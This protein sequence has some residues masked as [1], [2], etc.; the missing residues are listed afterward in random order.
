[1]TTLVRKRSILA[2]VETA[3]G[4][5]AAPTLADAVTLTEFSPTPLEATVVER[6]LLRPFVGAASELIAQRTTILNPTCEL[7]G[8][9]IDS[10]ITGGKAPLRPQFHALLRACGM[11]ETAI[12]KD[13]TAAASNGSDRVG[14]RY[15]T[16]DPTNAASVTVISQVDGIQ[17][18]I[19]GC[20][21]TFVI[22][23]ENGGIP[24]IAFTMTGRYRRPLKTALPTTGAR[25]TDVPP[26][27]VGS[28]NTVVTSTWRP[29]NPCVHTFSVDCGHTITPRDCVRDNTGTGIDV[30]ITDRTTTGSIV[31]DAKVDTTSLTGQAAEGDPWGVSGTGEGTAVLEVGANPPTGLI[32]HGL[33]AGEWWT[34]GGPSISIGAVTEEDRDGILAYGHPLRFAP[35][36]NGNNDFTITFWGDA[37]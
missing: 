16:G 28:D 23:G 36:G 22:S 30:L 24:T 29:L 33:S 26:S 5:S 9:G 21:G 34:V 12:K 27:L 11:V 6:N 25:P 14:W 4:T 8:G 10:A 3:Y 17:Q 15:T 2:K 31:A 37:S 32:R 7:V 35:T 1:M 19:V 20:R 18:L 13:G